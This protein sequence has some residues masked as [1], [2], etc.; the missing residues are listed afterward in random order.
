MTADP[1][2]FNGSTLNFNNA[3]VGKLI[4]LQ[5]RSRGTV[6]DVTE[7]GDLEKIVEVGLPDNELIANVKRLST[8]A[9]GATGPIVVTWHD[10]SNTPCN[11]TWIVTDTGG[12]GSWDAPI[13][14]DITF[15]RTV[16]VA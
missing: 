9:V 4:G 15:K 1:R 3:A 10:G 12:G 7:P 14:G 2:I 8:L 6:I 16:A 13:T 11:N 5:Y